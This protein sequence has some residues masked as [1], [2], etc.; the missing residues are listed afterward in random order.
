MPRSTKVTT[1]RNFAVATI[2]VMIGWFVARTWFACSAVIVSESM[3][4]ALLGPHLVGTCPVCRQ[5]TNVGAVEDTQQNLEGGRPIACQNCGTLIRLPRDTPIQSGDS[6]LVYRNLNMNRPLARWDLVACQD[7]QSAEK[8]I[9]KRVV[10]LPGETVQ[11]VD[12]DVFIDGQIARKSLDEQAAVAVL[13]YDAEHETDKV[14]NIDSAGASPT[15]KQTELPRRWISGGENSRWSANE[16][17]FHFAGAK[18]ESGIQKPADR[19]TY[20]HRRRVDGQ[21]VPGVVV[22]R[23][24]YNQWLPIRRDTFY[25][26]PDLMLAF[27]L[28]RIAGEGQLKIFIGN[29]RYAITLDYAQKKI[30]L[31]S[32]QTEGES[33]TP[34]ATVLAEVPFE[35]SPANRPVPILVS[36]VDRRL[37]VVIDRDIILEE[38]LSEPPPCNST[39]FAFGA[40]GLDLDLHRV[41]IYRDVYYVRPIGIQARWAFDTPVQ[42]GEDDYFILGDNSRVSQDSRTWPGG[43]AVSRSRIFGRP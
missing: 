10:G 25:P 27:H 19:L 16:G 1:V 41:R 17:R 21:M 2:L 40:V 11:I 34:K 31:E 6:L 30:I 3:A 8:V 18:T 29:D 43:P 32:F 12:G 28:T 39:P 23:L 9:V 37:T 26:V 14:N 5:T 13:V 36:T 15:A 42:L 20:H 22:D 4:P 33:E 35:P 24:A 38:P 7:P